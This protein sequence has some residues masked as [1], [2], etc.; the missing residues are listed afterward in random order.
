MISLRL[1][2]KGR[3]KG[4]RNS[5]LKGRLPLA[6]QLM[7]WR[8]GADARA[9][10]PVRETGV[11]IPPPP[12]LPGKAPWGGA[13]L[14][15]LSLG[16]QVRFQLGGGGGERSLSGLAA[17]LSPRHSGCGWLAGGRAGWLAGESRSAGSGGA[18]EK[19]AERL[20]R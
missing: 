13:A 18:E 17:S 11:F 7:A 4:A 16:R 10:V 9:R 15:S 5:T 14:P 1:F 20:A 12:C 6:R 2:L 8:G 3:D 19:P